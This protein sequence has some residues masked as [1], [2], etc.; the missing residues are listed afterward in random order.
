MARAALSISA[1]FRATK[2]SLGANYCVT[3]HMAVFLIAK[4]GLSAHEVLR[5]AD[6]RASPDKSSKAQAILLRTFILSM[7]TSELISESSIRK[8]QGDDC[9]SDYHNQDLQAQTHFNK[10][11]KGVASGGDD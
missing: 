3:I 11:H 1:F 5:A 4:R 6:Q 7:T 9:D 8:K 10:I 2:G